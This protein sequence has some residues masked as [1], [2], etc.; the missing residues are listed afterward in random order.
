MALDTIGAEFGEQCRVPDRVKITWYILGYGSDIMPSIEDLYPL[1]E[2][3]KQHTQG[4]VAS[5][6]TKLMTG[7]Q[8][9]GE[10][11]GFNV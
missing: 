6:E 2:E 1:L 4:R 8:V 9:I 3:Q 10:E 5:S 7:N 11:E